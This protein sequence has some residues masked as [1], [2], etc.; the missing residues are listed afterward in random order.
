M[1]RFVCV[2][3]FLCSSSAFAQSRP[4]IDVHFHTDT[5]K[6]LPR[7]V[8]AGELREL[9]P[10]TRD[11]MIQES[12]AV[13]NNLNIVYAI[14]SGPDPTIV[15]EWRDA[16][17]IRII[18]ALQVANARLDKAYLDSIRKLVAAGKIAVLGEV[19]LQYEGFDVSHPAYDAYFSLAEE[20]DIPI[21]VHLGPGPYDVFDVR[22]DYR[23]GIGDPLKLEGVLQRHPGL[24]LY[25]MHAGWPLIENM[26]AVMHTYRNVYVDTAFVNTAVPQDELHYVL[27]RL[28]G[29]GLG[30]RV[31]FGTDPHPG[32]ITLSIRTALERI[33]AAAFL[34]EEQKNDIFFAN[35][36]RFLRLSEGGRKHA[37]D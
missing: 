21:A 23:V 30:R 35:A 22:P 16:D 25:V 17:P 12:L 33:E 11:E 1:V 4:I 5:G 36:A 6:F 24:R 10:R 15:Q 37:Q 32:A 2:V 28:V 3:I 9:K 20:L 34:S 14:T 13:M 26:I 7:E 27:R 8:I 18:P 29:A 31:M 19:A